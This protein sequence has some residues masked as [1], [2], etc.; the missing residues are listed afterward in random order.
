MTHL[1]C[2]CKQN[3]KLIKLDFHQLRAQEICDPRRWV[4]FH[5]PTWRKKTGSSWFFKVFAWKEKQRSP[6]RFR[7]RERRQ[8][9]LHLMNDSEC[10]KQLT[11]MV[12]LIS[13]K[14]THFFYLQA[15]RLLIKMYDN[16]APGR[17]VIPSFV[18]AVI[19][20]ENHTEH[21]S[22]GLCLFFPPHA[23]GCHMLS[24]GA[25]FVFQA[26]TGRR[27]LK[28]FKKKKQKKK[29]QILFR[30]RSVGR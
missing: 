15:A 22:C 20:T 28:L 11:G 18:P 25:P 6:S 1:S 26:T 19:F 24:R 5:T 17:W 9:P 8:S 2:H 23:H 27:A 30:L 10:L 16:A 14:M 21:E 3:T 29:R 12:H 4:S 7:L 13:T